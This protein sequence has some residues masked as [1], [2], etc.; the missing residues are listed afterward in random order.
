MKNKKHISDYD[1][2]SKTMDMKKNDVG[3][4]KA[5]YKHDF[6]APKNHR[7]ADQ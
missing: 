2:E 6:F 1:L 7:L 3:K 5:V 4:K